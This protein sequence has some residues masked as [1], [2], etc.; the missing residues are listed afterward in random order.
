MAPSYC[1]D[2][3]RQ[4]SEKRSERWRGRGK[5]EAENKS[6]WGGERFGNSLAVGIEGGKE[7]ERE[8]RIKIEGEAGGSK[9]VNCEGGEKMLSQQN[10]SWPN[11]FCRSVHSIG[12]KMRN[13]EG[14]GGRVEGMKQNK[15]G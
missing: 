10:S 6:I 9:G 11:P 15:T 4:I 3:A 12:E 8:G 14:G 13:V 7:E 2:T 1:T 5:E